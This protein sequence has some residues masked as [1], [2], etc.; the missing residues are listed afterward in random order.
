MSNEMGS[1]IDFATSTHTIRTSSF[2]R[3]H[4]KIK[5]IQV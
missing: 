3:L 2:G 5:R 4:I 1:P